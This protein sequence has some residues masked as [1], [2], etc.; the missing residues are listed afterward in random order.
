MGWSF[1]VGSISGIRIRIHLTFLFFLIWIGASFWQRGGMPAAASGVAYILLL[2]L[3]VVLHEFGHILTA[4]RFGAQTLDVVLLPIG[5]LARMKQIPEKPGQELAVALAGPCVNLVIAAV[6][7][8]LVGPGAIGTAAVPGTDSSILTQLAVA[9]V[10][11][12][13]FNL[14]PAFPMDGGRALRALLAYRVGRVEATRLATRIGHVLAIGFGVFGFMTGNPL[15]ILIAAFIYF[16]AS[17][18]DHETQLHDLARRMK[19]SDAMITHFETLPVTATIADAVSILVHSTQ[20]DVP[21]VDGAGKMIGLLVRN[22]I[23]L[24]LHDHGGGYAVADAMQGGIPAVSTGMELDEALRVIEEQSLPAV[25]VAD[26]AGRLVGMV[27]V[28]Q[29]GQMLLLQRLNAG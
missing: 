5:G 7:I 9:N 12:A 13:V 19:V 29:L 23:L 8:A 16:G 28:E 22:R 21:I 10:F 27:T 15:L 18:E 3:C 20:H 6:L 4:R 26:H 24:A 11:L 17:A 2:F 14:V 1:S 25:A